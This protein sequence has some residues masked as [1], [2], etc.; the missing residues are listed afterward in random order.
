MLLM[1]ERRTPAQRHL[2]RYM[3]YR[4]AAWKHLSPQGTKWKV[5]VER[6]GIDKGT[7]ASIVKGRSSS[8]K[9]AMKLA[10]SIG[11]APLESFLRLAEAWGEAFP[12][13]KAED[14]VADPVTHL[15]LSTEDRWAE[16]AQIYTT[17]L[18]RA[19]R[20]VHLLEDD[21]TESMVQ[22]AMDLAWADNPEGS[23]R[24]AMTAR[25]WQVEIEQ[26]LKRILRGSGERPSAPKIKIARKV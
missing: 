3:A 11:P 23:A 10:S 22:A 1:T 7:F 21:A 5:L 9:L 14:P 19:G 20:A 16:M 25:E 8:Q 12:S 15:S 13:W 26:K 24:F 6:T 4:A 2:A 17:Q 18:I